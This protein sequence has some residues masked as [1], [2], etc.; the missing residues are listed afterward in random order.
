MGTQKMMHSFPFFIIYLIFLF[1][2]LKNFYKQA[3]K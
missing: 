2:D 3:L 1:E